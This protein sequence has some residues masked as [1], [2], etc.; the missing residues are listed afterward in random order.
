M[1][2]FRV[3]LNG[4]LLKY[5]ISPTTKIQATVDDG[6]VIAQGLSG[7]EGRTSNQYE[8]DDESS[9]IC[10]GLGILVLCMSVSGG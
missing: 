4:F 7:K 9:A 8:L 6:S 2:G 5:Q 1:I 3:L 10:N